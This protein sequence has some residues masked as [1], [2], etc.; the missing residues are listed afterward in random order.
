MPSGQGIGPTTVAVSGASGEGGFAVV[1][2]PTNKKVIGGGFRVRSFY[3]NGYRE[4]TDLVKTDAPADQ[5]RNGWHAQMWKGT[6][7]ALA[8]CA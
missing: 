6:I 2:C 5:G 4:V 3:Q 1:Q 8:L 7:Q